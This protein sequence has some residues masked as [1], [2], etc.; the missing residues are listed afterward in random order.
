MGTNIVNSDD[1]ADSDA[2]KAYFSSNWIV[3]ETLVNALV[4]VGDKHTTDEPDMRNC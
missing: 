2:G 3:I 4:G 1:V